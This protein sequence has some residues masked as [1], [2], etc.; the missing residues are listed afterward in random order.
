MINGY[1]IAKARELHGL[2]N[3]QCFLIGAIKE[4]EGMGDI[5]IIRLIDI[6]R[7][8]GIGCLATLHKEIMKTVS[9]GYFKI[10]PKPNDSRVK[11]I[12]LTNKAE[13]YLADLNKGV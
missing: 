12:T 3:Y 6:A 9:K 5:S 4:W 13:K 2:N 1:T 7:N 8:A 10:N 11:F